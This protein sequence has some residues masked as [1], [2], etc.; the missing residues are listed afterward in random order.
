MLSDDVAPFADVS[1]IADYEIV[2][3]HI[4]VAR[5]GTPRPIVERLNAEMKRI[6]ADPEIRQRIAGMGLIP[7]TPPPIAET[8]RYLKAEAAKWRAILTS[9]GLEGS[10]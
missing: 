2:A 9:M 10:M 7:I 5:A 8:E 1:G 3:W 6:M 4:L